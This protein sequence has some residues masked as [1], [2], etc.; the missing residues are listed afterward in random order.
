MMMSL[1]AEAIAELA[2]TM[3][4]EGSCAGGCGE[5]AIVE[6]TLEI[7]GTYS[8]VFGGLVDNGA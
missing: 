7:M 1:A 8:G 5:V 6:V 2:V 4:K 3:I